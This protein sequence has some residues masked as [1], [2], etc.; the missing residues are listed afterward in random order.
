MRIKGVTRGIWVAILLVGGTLAG[1]SQTRVT[2]TV[3]DRSGNPAAHAYVEA[4]PVIAVKP[5]SDGVA[6]VVGDIGDPWVAADSSGKFN[7]F[8]ARGRYRIRA[9][10]EGDG[11]PDPT[12]WLGY[13]STAKFPEIQVGKRDIASVDVILGAQ[14]GILSGRV[15][16][17]ATHAPVAGVTIRMQ[18]ARH[19]DYFVEVF[20]H[21]GG[22]FRYTVPMRPILISASASGYKNFKVGSG[23][24]QTLSRGEHRNIEIELERK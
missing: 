2:G 24:E 9:K 19:R 23:A 1:S 17:A 12:F 5:S 20:T 8:L 10:A 22:D 11:Y 18:D 15:R 14:G 16:D 4:I 13:D 3:R 21:A 7:L 6:G